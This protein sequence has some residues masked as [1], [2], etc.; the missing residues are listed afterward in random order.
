MTLKA[1]L[2]C[3]ALC[4]A[5]GALGAEGDVWTL[6]SGIH[7]SSGDY[8][9][10][11]TTDILSIPLELRYERAQ[12]TFRF[13]LPYVE[14]DGTGS[15]VP[16][17]GAVGSSARRRDSAAGL[18]DLVAAATYAALYDPGAQ[19]GLDLT[20][21]VKAATADEDEGLG[22]GEHDFAVLVEAYKTFDRTTLF[23][24]VG[25]HWLGDPPGLRLNDV[26]SWSLGGS[27][28]LDARDSA[29]LVYD[30]REALTADSGKLRELTAFFSR[31]LDRR[32]KGQAYFLMGLA[33]GSPDWGA[34]LSAGYSF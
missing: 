9:T 25:H 10:S 32:W 28:R 14:I 29:G 7:Y 15:V 26:W 16:G 22:T 5:Q 6:G 20:A 3:G 12:W 31:K 8:G 13:S 2:L 21:K 17:L 11:T 4:F 24:G 19:L 34:G 23:A 33:D 30:E 1:T 27:Y 18:G